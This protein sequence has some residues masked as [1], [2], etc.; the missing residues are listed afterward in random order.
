MKYRLVHL[1][2]SLAGRVR[3]VDATRIVL[4]RDPQEAQVVFGPDDRLVGRRHAQLSEE[5]GA[6]VLRDLDSRSGTFLDGQDIEEAE[7]ADGDVFELGPGGPRL[8]V[9]FAAGGTL[10]LEG[11][12]VPSAAAAAT[13]AP[14]HAAP[15]PP[16]GSKLRLTFLSGTRRDSFL[17]LAGSVIRIGR[18]PGSAVWT[19]DDRVVS[20]QHAKIVRLDEGYVVMDLEST[21]GTFVNGHRVERALL[22][23]GDV[24]G[25]GAG[26]P[27][28][29]VQ[30]L[31]PELAD[32]GSLATVV[33]P[34]FAELASRSS[35]TSLIREIPLDRPALSLGRGPEA[36][37]VLDSPIVSKLHARLEREGD[38]LVLLD[39]GSANGTYFNG[40]RVDRAALA[41]GD[42][43]VVGPFELELAPPLLRL[44]DTRSRARLDAQRLT[45]TAGGRPILDDVSLSLPP[46]SF[47]AVIGPSGSGKSTLLSALNASRPAP[48]GQVLLNG[49]DLYRSFQSLKSSL[50]YV[51]QDDIV[52]PELTVG[53]SLDYTARL[54]LPPDTAPA[55]R[56]KRVADVLATLELTERRDVEVGRL[57]GGQRKR[58]S[59]ATELLTEPNVLFLDEPTSGLDPGLEEALMLLLR[60]LAYKGKTV[61][62]VTHTLDHIHLCDAV[63]L[64]VDGRLAFYGPVVEARAYF[65]IEHMVN[66]YA[67]LKERPAS[68][69]QEQFRG[70][71]GYRARCRDAE[72]IRGVAA[73]PTSPALDRPAAGRPRRAGAWRQ[74]RVL[75]VRYLR[76]L[77]RDRRNAALLLAQAPL[78]AGL[79]GLS[80]LYGAADVAYTK[81]KNTLLLLLALVAVWFGCSNAVRELV[82]ERAIYLRERM[83]NL[84]ILPYVLSKVLVLGSLAAVQCVLFLAILDTWFGVPGRTALLLASMLLASVVGILLGLALSALARTGDR[85]MTLLPIALIPQIL[86]TF[87]AVQMDMKG[88]AGLV[89]RAMPTWWSFDLLRRV[90]LAPDEAA[91]NDAIDERLRL[92]GSVLMTKARIEAMLGEGYLLFNYRSSIEATWTASLPEELGRALPE[93]LGAWR[94]AAIDALALVG[95]AVALLAA[96]ALL[97]RR[98]DRRP[99]G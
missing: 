59:I 58:V 5:G 64:L 86:F 65:D 26:G 57:S 92:G 47:T 12:G 11:G 4:G 88:P 33:I 61:V 79:I 21:N 62:L 35:A 30:I 73:T 54:R 97:Q 27:E 87:P 67:R 78:I 55:E 40:R 53:E 14:R 46:G 76:V 24:V 32:R 48:R 34:N 42:R 90:A 93:R 60:E 69:W 80:L 45:V 82:K 81:P 13:L 96:T 18:A 98:H 94:P 44:F 50:G 72:P 77:G 37:V 71:E 25:L 15:P 23:T 66:L 63:A 7:L 3:E 43:V 99:T 16:P 17:E 91:S 83:V 51:P 38:Q 8:R 31:T 74:L 89:A 84:R 85:A 28:I 39:L 22:Q 75:T 52:H 20:A 6:L 56:G 1:T 36:E 70:S 68:E 49:T 29:R 19:P 2:G 41:A 9:E 95:F 10:V